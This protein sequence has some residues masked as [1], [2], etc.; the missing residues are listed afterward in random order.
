[1][2]DE[3]SRKQPDDLGGSPLYLL[4]IA[5]RELGDKARKLVF[6]LEIRMNGLRHQRNM[7]AL[8]LVVVLLA[9]IWEAGQ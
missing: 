1:M 5:E 6:Q 8:G 3:K 9:S 4:M 2:S 7:L